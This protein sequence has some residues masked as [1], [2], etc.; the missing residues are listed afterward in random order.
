MHGTPRYGNQWVAIPK[1]V[2][3]LHPLGRRKVSRAYEAKG[4][5]GRPK[6]KGRRGTTWKECMGKFQ[7]YGFVIEP[8][9]DIYG[10]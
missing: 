4:K 1:V 6:G 3:C 5:R 8:L 7:C 9:Q 2:A 10:Y